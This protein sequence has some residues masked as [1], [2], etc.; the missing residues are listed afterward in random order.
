M[1]AMIA[2]SWEIQSNI[3]TMKF[4]LSFYKGYRAAEVADPSDH[5]FR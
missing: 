5:F 3:S 4:F 2:V 1:I